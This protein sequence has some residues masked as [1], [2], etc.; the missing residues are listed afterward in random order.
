MRRATRGPGRLLTP[1]RFNPRPRAAGD[2]LRPSRSARSFNPRPRAA[3]DDSSIRTLADSSSFNPRPRAAGDRL[4]DEPGPLGKRFNPRPRAAGDLTAVDADGNSC[5]FQSTPACGGRR[6][7]QHH[8]QLRTVSIHARVRRATP[9]P[10]K[11]L[12]R[13][14]SF[15]PRPRAAGDMWPDASECRLSGFNPRPRA[16]GDRPEV[17]VAAR[18]RKFQS[19]PACGGRPLLR[20]SAHA[21]GRVSIH[22]RARRA[23]EPS[24]PRFADSQFQSTPAR[25]GRPAAEVG[26]RRAASGFNP[27]PRA[28]GDASTSSADRSELVSIHARARRATRRRTRT[29]A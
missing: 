1:D 3:G 19:T 20:R 15:N 27:R 12:R 5:E 18:P 11:C 2:L 22:A 26:Q 10:P 14:P 24:G 23:T 4:T 13:R 21:G 29:S 9:A 17:A 25:G 6:Q 28:A 7:G 16:A 8:E